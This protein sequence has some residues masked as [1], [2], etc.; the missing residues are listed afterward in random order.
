MIST[1]TGIKAFIGVLVDASL[2]SIA[3]RSA[4]KV[5][6]SA[7]AKKESSPISTPISKA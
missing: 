2:S 7:M 1:I 6:I 5:V 4:L 3:V